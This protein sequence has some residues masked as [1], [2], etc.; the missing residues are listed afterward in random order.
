M[1]TQLWYHG[2]GCESSCNFV[3]VIVLCTGTHV[4]DCSLHD[5]GGDDDADAAMSSIGKMIGKTKLEFF[6]ALYAFTCSILLEDA[7]NRKLI[8]NYNGN[9]KYYSYSLTFYC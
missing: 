2:S 1:T 3:D 8:H 5:N 6:G 9:N 4:V 7:H